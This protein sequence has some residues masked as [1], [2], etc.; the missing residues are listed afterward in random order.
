MRSQPFYL[1]LSLSPFP[2]PPSDNHTFTSI[3]KRRHKSLFL[4]WSASAPLSHNLSKCT[5]KREFFGTSAPNIRPICERLW[6]ENSNSWFISRRVELFL[7]AKCFKDGE[8]VG[9][10]SEGEYFLW[11]NS[12]KI[13]IYDR[14]LF[15]ELSSALGKRRRFA[16]CYYSSNS[17]F[18]C[19]CT[20]KRVCCPSCKK[21]ANKVDRIGSSISDRMRA[22][23]LPWNTQK[24]LQTQRK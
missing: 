1:D 15:P 8:E 14:H 16:E 24:N 3:Q 2:F 22:E 20:I 9:R 23:L 4:F 5:Q 17:F 19:W 12:G 13:G 18:S 7:R 6:A 21:W 10:E 11:G